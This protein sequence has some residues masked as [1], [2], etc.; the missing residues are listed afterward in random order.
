[1]T[2]FKEVLRFPNHWRAFVF[3]FCLTLSGFSVIP[4]IMPYL[5]ANLGFD[6]KHIPLSYFCGG[7]ATFFSAPWIGRMSDKYGK[8]RTFQLA[9]LLSILPIL[10]I[11]HLQTSNLYVVLL[12]M[13]GFMVFV[14]GRFVPAVALTSAATR[15][16]MR[17]AFMS[18][19]S[20]VLQLGFGIASLSGGWLLTTEA[21]GMLSGYPVVGYMAVAFTLLTMWLSRLVQLKDV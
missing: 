9:A 18:L 13:V 14:S 11:T 15:P 7:V 20:S 8:H 1:M 19:H 21:N 3:I 10:M 17:G 16:H 6:Q 2:A 4:F 12:L 5:V